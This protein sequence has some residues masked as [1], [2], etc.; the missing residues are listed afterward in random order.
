MGQPVPKRRR[1]EDVHL[2]EPFGQSSPAPHGSA[3]AAIHADSL[4]MDPTEGAEGDYAWASWALSTAQDVAPP[5]SCSTTYTCPTV[6]GQGHVYSG[7]STPT[8]CRCEV[9]LAAVE[10]T[11]DQPAHAILYSSGLAA[12][13]AILSHFLP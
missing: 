6:E 7:M 11:A 12:C 1:E 10:G 4:L 13:F 8:L 5:I 3:T 9:L 2:P